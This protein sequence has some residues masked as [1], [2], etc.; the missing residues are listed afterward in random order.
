MHLSLHGVFAIRQGPW[1]LIPNH[2]GSGG[3]SQPRDLDP[4]AAYAIY[5]DEEKHVE[6]YRLEYD[7]DAVVSKIKAIPDLSDWLGERLREGR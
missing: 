6:F 3:F 1:K 7:I 4:R 2:R 5:D